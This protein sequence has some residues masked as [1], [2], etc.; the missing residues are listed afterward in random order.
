MAEIVHDDLGVGLAR[1]VI[2]GQ[3]E[4]GGA[5]LGE[6]RQ[7]AVEREAEPFPF[8]AVRPLKRLR[9]GQIVGAAGRVTDMADG[10][11]PGELRHD[12]VVLGRMV[13]A[14]RL[15]NRAD[16]FVGIEDALPPR[17]ERREPRR[18]L[19]AI[20]QIKQHAGHQSRDLFG[21]C[22]RGKRMA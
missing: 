3:I 17:V 6:I 9:I 8:A 15:D 13:E 1:Q 2:V 4:E 11:A 12:V 10:R 16:L 14:K 18:Q 20:L 21:T 7:L 22:E 19:P 5:Q